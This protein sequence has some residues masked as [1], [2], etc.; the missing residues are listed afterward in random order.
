MLAGGG[1][2]PTF[3]S[4]AAWKRGPGKDFLTAERVLRAQTAMHDPSEAN[5]ARLHLA[6]FYLANQFAAEALGL[7]KIIQ[8]TDP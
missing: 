3:L 8:T 4:L 7:I 2:G 1:D 5:G 6:R